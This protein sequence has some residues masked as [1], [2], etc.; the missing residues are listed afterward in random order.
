MLVYQELVITLKTN[1]NSDKD[2]AHKDDKDQ[3]DDKKVNEKFIQNKIDK[4]CNVPVKHKIKFN[5][6]EY[7]VVTNNANA[8]N[9]GGG[10]ANAESRIRLAS[11]S[12]DFTLGRYLERIA[13]QNKKLCEKC[14]KPLTSHA[15]EIYHK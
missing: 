12:N 3:D 7:H 14:S 13:R 8:G 2:D 4:I 15:V 1:L 10:E 9:T 5:H 11:P 6:Q